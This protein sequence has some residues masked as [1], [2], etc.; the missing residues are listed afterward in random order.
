MKSC[1]SCGLE[2]SEEQYSNF[3]GMCPECIRA[4]KYGVIKEHQPN[5]MEPCHFCNRVAT[6]DCDDCGKPLCG[7]H[8]HQ[9]T[10]HKDSTEIVNRC[11]DCEDEYSKQ[12]AICF[13]FVIFAVL[14]IFII[15]LIGAAFV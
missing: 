15:S 14:G 6:N 4:K 2:I 13:V 9:R 3:D 7:W 1:T 8:M 12:S 5:T 11:P 10:V